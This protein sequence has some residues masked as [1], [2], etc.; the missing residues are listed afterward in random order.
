MKK[1]YVLL[2]VASLM[3]FSCNDKTEGYDPGNSTEN[4]VELK[5]VQGGSGTRAVVPYPSDA[6]TDEEKTIL[7]LDLVAFDHTT[8]KFVYTRPAYPSSGSTYRA[9]V[10]S[11]HT[12]VDVALLA[13]CPGADIKSLLASAEWI[14]SEQKWE[15]FQ[16]LLIDKS[17]ARL[18]NSS[19]FK[20]LPMSSILL[21]DKSL[22]TDGIANWGTTQLLRSVASVDFLMEKNT[23]TSK[24]ELVQIH[25]YYAP[26]QGYITSLK[27]AAA[28]PQ[29]YKTPANMQTTLNTLTANRIGETQTSVS[30]VVAYNAITSQLYMYDNNHVT[31]IHTDIN[32]C[33]RIIVEGYYDQKDVSGIKKSTFYPIFLVKD[34]KFRP[35][36]RNWKYLIIVDAVYGP[37]YETITE[38]AQSSPINLNMEIIDWELEEGLNIGASDPYYVSL[39]KKVATLSRYTDSEDIINITY[40]GEENDKFFFDFDENSTN[41]TQTTITNGIA[42]NRFEVTLTAA[43]GK[44]ILTVKAKGNYSTTNDDLNH[45]TVILRYRNLRFEIDI[46]QLDAD[47][48]DWKDGGDISADL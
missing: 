40:K 17:P 10:P 29:Q 27:E 48:L 36:I 28:T 5:I 13:N 11:Q 21:E 6:G 33:T 39:N 1:I 25:A 8:K 34:D 18:V 3:G 20:P 23:A 15:D 30:P 2:L 19:S 47:K 16:T 32:K 9:T 38:A 12:T 42:N 45:D 35:I 26:N 41:G 4:E 24:L 7:S 46:H 37:G 43:N 44:A 14:G 22:V 31:N